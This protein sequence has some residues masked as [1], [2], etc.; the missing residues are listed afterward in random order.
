MF[1]Y[2]E[3]ECDSSESIQDYVAAKTN[4]NPE[5]IVFNSDTIMGEIMVCNQEPAKLES[6]LIIHASSFTK[7]DLLGVARLLKR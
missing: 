1:D 3:S 4:L 7:C 2:K 5:T 6:K